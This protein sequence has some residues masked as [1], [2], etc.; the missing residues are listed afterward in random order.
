MSLTE[1]LTVLI[2]GDSS[3]LQQEL[4]QVAD[5]LSGLQQQLGDLSGSTSQFGEALQ[6]LGST[7]RPLQGISTQLT[8]ISEQLQ[9]ISQQ[10]V[11]IDVGSAVMSL[12]QLLQAAQAV[13][14]QL[15]ALSMGAALGGMITT[16]TLGG[17]DIPARGYA[18]GGLVSG[19]TGIDQVRARLTAGEYVLNQ[20]AVAAI[21]VRTLDRL[22]DSGAASEALLP[23]QAG[24]IPSVLNVQVPTPAASQQ[25]PPFPIPSPWPTQGRRWDGANQLSSQSPPRSRNTAAAQTNNHFGGIEIKIQETADV[26]QLLRSLRLE[27]IGLR[28]R[29]G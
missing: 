16:T 6:G 8:S 7:A 14:Q 13:A 4:G 3:G 2:L 5:S 27:G 10:P 20:D 25:F 23:G 18:T 24:P 11:S 9:S 22:N 12:Q 29:R 17:S 21:G 28:H 19:P 15:A 26:D 1:S